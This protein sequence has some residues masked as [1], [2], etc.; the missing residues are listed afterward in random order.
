MKTNAFG[1]ASVLYDMAI[2]G[3]DGTIP[4]H[5]REIPKTGFWV[6]GKFPS[7]VFKHPEDIDRG[8]L[9]WWVGL[10]PA[11]WYGVWVDSEDGAI[12]FDGAT[13]M[14]HEDFARNLAIQRG[15]IAIWDVASEKEIR[16]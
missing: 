2:H 3:E 7:L 9:A 15:E 8:E 1:L 12:Y 14:V 5:D 4:R 13:H 6:G 11:S 16:V 10:N